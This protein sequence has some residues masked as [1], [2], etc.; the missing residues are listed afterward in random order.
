MGFGQALR[1]TQVPISQSELADASRA[2]GEIPVTDRSA[3][4][5]ALL[6]CLIKDPMHIP[7]FEKLFEVFFGSVPVT[8][9]FRNPSI[10]PASEE[11]GGD[12]IA[13]GLESDEIR[14]GIFD[15]LFEGDMARLL[16]LVRQAVDR[17][18]GVET[19]RAVSGVYYTYRTL[20][21]LDTEQLLRA[22]L[23]GLLSRPE[24]EE[25][26]FQ[27]RL[28]KDQANRK[29]Q[30]LKDVVAEE[31]TRRLVADRG[32]GAVAKT[33]ALSLPEDL[34]IVHATRDELLTLQRAMGPLA[35]KLAARLAQRHRS[36]R[37]A[38]LDFRKTIREALS[39]G[40]VPLDVYFKPP[41]QSKPEIFLIADIS[42][43]VASFARFTMQLVYAMSAQFSKVRSFVFIDEV[44]EVTQYFSNARDINE[45]LRLVNTK[46][47]VVWLDGH[48]DYGHS[49]DR[50]E[51]RFGDQVT[52]R[53]SVIICGDARNNYHEPGTASL[54][55]VRARAKHVF[56]LNP[57]PRSYWDTGDSIISKYG[58]ECDGVFECR[59]LRQLEDF[60]SEAI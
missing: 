58:A 8:D 28:A 13:L 45:S 36:K 22:I 59:T 37:A 5:A 18:G 40:G 38:S 3:F 52:R 47:K 17:F 48:S 4:K 49:I 51:E 7:A 6:A 23:A 33:L 29:I 24:E 43:S 1:A 31:V 53:T 15:A 12:D 50:F 54:R 9:A 46:A 26:A 42:G 32:A 10:E 21:Q 41:R 14:Q 57:E 2:L 11:E 27:N 35:K 55:R 39:S 20:R 19:G 30:Q 44:D 25:S 60:V 56:W 34:D 16:E